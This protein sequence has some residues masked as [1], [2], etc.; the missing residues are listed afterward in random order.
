MSDYATAL[1]DVENY[2]TE[3]G[4]LYD[5]INESL[6]ANQNVA[7]ATGQNE[8]WTNP[9][10]DGRIA[11]WTEEQ[12]RSMA[13]AEG[14]S[15]ET[16]V[17][18]AK[19]SM[20][21]ALRM[22]LGCQIYIKAVYPVLG[23]GRNGISSMST[24]QPGGNY[25][26]PGGSAQS[27]GP[28][29]LLQPGSTTERMSTITVPDNLILSEWTTER[30][31]YREGAGT[32]VFAAPA[33][34]GS[35]GTINTTPGNQSTN[36]ALV[37]LD[38]DAT[39]RFT[40]GCSRHG[41]SARGIA[42]YANTVQ[43]SFTATQ[44]Q[45]VQQLQASIESWLDRLRCIVNAYNDFNQAHSDALSDLDDLAEET[46]PGS[47]WYD[48]LIPDSIFGRFQNEIG[49]YGDAEAYAVI[50]A[51]MNA[52]GS[53]TLGGFLES[54]VERMIFKEQC[55]LLSYIVPITTYKKDHLN[56][57]GV[58]N[59]RRV[60][61]LPYLAQ[62]NNTSQQASILVDGDGYGFINR[63]TQAR[64]TAV[65]NHIM[66][67]QLSSLQ[68]MIRLFKV[69]SDSSTGEQRQV[70]IKFESNHK[71]LENE[72]HSALRT[73]ADRGTGVGIKNFSFTYDGSNPFAI[74][75]SIKGTLEIFANSFEDL[76][77]ERTSLSTHP[78]TKI[79]RY[80]DLALKTS[81]GTDAPTIDACGGTAAVFRTQ[82]QNANLEKLN[83]RL[84]ACVGWARPENLD[85]GR[86]TES[87]R[88]AMLDVIYD[89]Y[90]TLD[91]TPTVHDFTFDEQGRVIFRIN[92][93][94][95]IEDFY[96]QNAFNIFA[97]AQTF[98][99]GSRRYLT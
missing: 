44:L 73:S 45:Q 58:N 56:G 22:W 87:S 29:A 71:T 13:S 88:N 97:D 7:Q 3:L 65:Y 25:W 67:S 64:T 26:Y 24:T 46:R 50:N 35:I 51:E 54:N 19:R 70:E 30:S 52:L 96:D 68:P 76:L 86:M 9:Q 84:K 98:G 55:F 82:E 40:Y 83:F 5:T 74:K 21:D 61:R 8:A 6:S 90:V 60:K 17:D 38:A 92:Y 95:Y 81:G 85:M 53:M 15:I 23:P 59:P 16:V 37:Q 20:A 28:A 33:G 31:V 89:S 32:S 39:S 99:G 36:R 78:N 57:G 4:N 27:Q 18:A 11:Y 49:Q 47:H 77:D 93:L 12:I 66:P 79:Y 1:D 2:F 80:I 41:I 14:T 10:E 72:L 63:L 42:I 94:A 75:K 69:F 91:L 43:A 34:Q 62:G 48:Y